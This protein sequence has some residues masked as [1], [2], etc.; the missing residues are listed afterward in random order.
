MAIEKNAF[1][2]CLTKTFSKNGIGG[3]LSLPRNEAFYRLAEH[4]LT[5]NEK[6]NLTSI[7]DPERIIYLHFA[8]SALLCP[9]IPKNAVL[10]D[11]GC[12]GG[13]PSLPIAICRP[14]VTVTALDSTEK[15]VNYVRGAAELLGLSNVNT[16][17]ARAEEA[18]QLPAYREKFNLVTARAVAELRVLAELSLPFVAVGGQ[19][20]AMKSRNAQN[21]LKAAAKAIPTLGGKWKSSESL[22]LLSETGEEAERTVITVDKVGR[23]SPTYPRPYA[24]ISKKPL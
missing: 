23:T 21:E 14:D 24:K 2:S 18:A 1:I 10:L 15:K 7:T 22:L 8:D 3:L 6:Y 17:C 5:E 16:L 19:F 20:V 13:F 9:Y 12:G 4:M 11:V